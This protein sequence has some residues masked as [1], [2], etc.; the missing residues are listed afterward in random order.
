MALQTSTPVVQDPR[1]VELGINVIRGI[2]MDAPEQADSG[3]PGTAMALAPL[4]HVLWTRIMKYDP[5]SPEWP[6]LAA[7]GAS[8]ARP[9][10]TLMPSSTN[11]GSCTTC[12]DVGGA[13]SKP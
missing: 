5:R 7:S 12:V 6:E 13:M 10:T 1:L 11:L 3:H 4:A 9:R 2:A 8:M